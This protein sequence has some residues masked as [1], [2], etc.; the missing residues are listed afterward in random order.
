M[1]M[2][3]ALL[4]RP[5][6]V[7]MQSIQA[8]KWVLVVLAVAGISLGHVEMTL[9]WVAASIA[10]GL[11][12]WPY[13]LS[14]GAH[15][16]FSHGE[17]AMPQWLEN[18]WAVWQNFAGTGSSTMWGTLHEVHHCQSDGPMDPHS[19][20]ELG[21]WAGLS[22]FYKPRRYSMH[23]LA[24]YLRQP[25]IRF[26]HAYH[27]AIIVAGAGLLF[28]FSVE[29]FV[30]LYRAERACRHNDP[31]ATVVE[32]ESPSGDPLRH[33]TPSG[34]ILADGPARRCP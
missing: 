13:T 12:V 15:R 14:L 3:K 5:S 20:H 19:P 4:L 27:N 18:A 28:A 10:M 30:W 9:G 22:G 32:V 33:G 1:T 25:V 23:L 24:V 34:A 31:A 2:N 7:G 16:Y 17:F 29:A 26:A 6:A 11:V 21:I 8:A